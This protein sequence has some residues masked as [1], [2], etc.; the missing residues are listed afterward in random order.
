MQPVRII[1]L[2]FNLLGE[3]DNYESLQFIRRH[4]R[5]GEFELHIA[6]GKRYVDELI[7]DRVIF[8][9]NQTQK[10]GYIISRDIKLNEDGS[11]TVV[12]K[13]PTLGGILDRRL[14]I[15]D[16]YD[17]VRGAAET[18]MKYYVNRH[19]VDGVYP[20]R[21]MPFFICAPDQARGI[22]IPWQTRYEPLDQVIEKIANRCE[23]GWHVSLNF[24]TKRWVF[25]VQTG[26]DL[27]VDQSIN[28]PVIFSR[29]FDNVSSQQ[30]IDSDASYR[31]VGYAGGPGE[32]E[33][34]TVLV[35]GTASGFDRREV[36]L[37]ASEAADAAEI[38]ELGDVKLAGYRQIKTFDGKVIDTG[39]FIYEQDWD[40]GD[41]VTLQNL[42][43]G[44][45]SNTR[46]IE[47]REIYEQ[48]VKIEVLLGDEIPTIT[49]VVRSLQT[50]VGRTQLIGSTGERGQ[51]GPQGP[52]GPAGPKGDQGLQGPKGDPGPQG[53]QGI[54]GDKGDVG[55][56]GPIGPKGDTG[57]RGPI[58]LTGAKGD[59]GIQGPKGDTGPQGLAGPK[60]DKGEPGLK[61]DTGPKG[62]TGLQG[63]KGDKGDQG[64]QGIQ[65]PKGDTGA[66]GLQ[67]PKGDTGASG[68]KGADGKT[69]LSG[70]T[71]PTSATGSD[72]D[73][74]INTSSN[75]I[76]GPKSSS[77]WGNGKSLIGPKGDKGDI[78]PQGIQG[79]KG[80]KGDT[81]ATG[82][83]GLQGP[84]GDTGDKGPQGPQGIQ[85][86]KGDTGPKGDKG[87][88]GIQGPQGTQGIQ[89]PKGDKGDRGEQGIQGPP[90]TS[91]GL[92][93][94][95]P[96]EPTGIEAG[97]WWYREV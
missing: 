26:R 80:D 43:W 38:A 57:E 25:D 35:I 97:D 29:G 7:K 64:I 27:T 93:V 18:V 30:F 55:P 52:I 12:V 96:T 11:E 6:V 62:D 45:Q 83:T 34:Q 95:S 87:D 14:T 94:A 31:N 75:V 69:I 24:D 48:E 16:S 46:I 66:T 40:L 49:S 51:E 50:Q 20:E 67:G 63:P 89:G 84:K 17:R 81:G 78:G 77:S 42:D 53:L 15:T 2:D 32:E 56:Q 59:Q 23:L 21:K 74:Y 71:N 22:E 10:A 37:D 36:Y 13:G 73:F 5:A 70:T 44:L 88:Q 47:V 65:G 85:G 60:G 61:G 82:A 1:D 58:G 72:G 54:K 90:G 79:L 68:Q 86:L 28:P 76:F 92:I 4:F 33:D 9:G 19:I 39:S 3:I 91:G 41:I 8:L